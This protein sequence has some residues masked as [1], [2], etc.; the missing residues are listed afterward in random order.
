[1]TVSVPSYDGA[2]VRLDDI[3]GGDL[4]VSVTDD[5]VTISGDAEGLKHLARWCLAVSSALPG[6]HV[7][8]DPGLDL[9]DGSRSLIVELIATDES[10]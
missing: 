3:V 2:G 4:N 5:E 7:H 10:S 9:G 1:M 8:P 6:C